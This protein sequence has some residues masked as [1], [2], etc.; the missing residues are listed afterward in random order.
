MLRCSPG[1]YLIYLDKKH[2]CFCELKYR[3]LF[4]QG[5]QKATRSMD[6]L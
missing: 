1:Q 5:F 3:Y 4:F 2:M 6:V